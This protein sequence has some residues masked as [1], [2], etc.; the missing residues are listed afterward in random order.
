MPDRVDALTDAQRETL[1][2]YVRDWIERGTDCAPLDDA[3]RAEV[4]AGIRR[5]Y[6]AAGLPWHGNVVWVGSPV[7]GA[8]AVAQAVVR[9]ER[10]RN[11]PPPLTRPAPRRR[12]VG[13][14]VRIGAAV[15]VVAGFLAAALAGTWAGVAVYAGLA[16]APAVV[17]AVVGGLF[18]VVAV[19]GSNSR[20]KADPGVGVALLGLVGTVVFALEGASIGAWLSGVRTGLGSWFGP[21]AGAGLRWGLAAAVAGA[22][23][24][25]VVAAC[26]R[27][28]V[29]E[30]P[31]PPAP[32]PALDRTAERIWDAVPKA[33]RV[34]VDTAIS[35]AVRDEVARAAHD[36]VRVALRGLHTTTENVV[37]ASLDD[38]RA[39]PLS[40]DERLL[41]QTVAGVADRLVTAVAGPAG[42]AQSG[43]PGFVKAPRLAEAVSPHVGGAYAASLL[44]GP[45]WLREHAGLRL[46]GNLWGLAD[47]YTDAGRAG[48]WWPNADFV[49]IS[50][51]PREMSVVESDDHLPQLHREDGP[52]LRWS[53]GVTAWCTHGRAADPPDRIDYSGGALTGI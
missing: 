18:A 49:V 52:A 1:A 24:A 40:A 31:R 14:I 53:D 26:T 48:W 8:A 4:V 3:G 21:A 17:G 42:P 34:A 2:P 5:C 41:R 30:P 36:P 29:P 44:A 22:V 23:V 47:A 38:Y 15:G 28:V 50:E 20:S 46:P 13:E 9:I 25:A 19:V 32:E 7:V 33:V 45:L 12:R 6:E 11:P 27:V 37:N 43:T 39:V 10:F 16:G 51:R 35:D